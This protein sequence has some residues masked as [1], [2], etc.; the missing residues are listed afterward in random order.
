MPVVDVEAALR[1][2]APWVGDDHAAGGAATAPSGAHE[3]IIIAH[4]A[5]MDA[6]HAHGITV[7]RHHHVRVR[8][9]HDAIRSVAAARGEIAVRD[10]LVIFA[11][12]VLPRDL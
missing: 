8:S 2:E 7:T 10:M 4:I 6:L 5:A 11:A 1:P 3:A 9:A 12:Q